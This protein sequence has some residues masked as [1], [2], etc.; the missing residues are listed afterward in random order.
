MEKQKQEKNIKNHLARV[1]MTGKILRSHLAEVKTLILL[2]QKNKNNQ[3]FVLIS[4][5]PD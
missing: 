3:N 2:Q 4:V 5:H 1:K